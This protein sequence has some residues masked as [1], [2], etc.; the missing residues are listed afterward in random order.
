MIFLLTLLP[1][2]F[3]SMITETINYCL[4]A[5]SLIGFSSIC[6]LDFDKRKK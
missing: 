5:G 3:T 1:I 4:I 2:V 6:L